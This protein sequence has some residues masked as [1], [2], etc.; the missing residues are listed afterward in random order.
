MDQVSPPADPPGETG[1]TFPDQPHAPASRAPG[2]TVGSVLAWALRQATAPEWSLLRPAEQL[3]AEVHPDDPV[4]RS[5][6]LAGARARL[7]SR[8]GQRPTPVETRALATLAVA[9]NLSSDQPGRARRST[10]HAAGDRAPAAAELAH[11][12]PPG[13]F[14]A[15]R[16]ELLQLA[17]HHHAPPAALQLLLALPAQRVFADLTAALRSAGIPHTEGPR[18]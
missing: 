9:L 14:P 5:A 18:R 8:V 12:L 16:E 1:S 2:R 3:V 15:D 11:Y 13:C 17:V 6:V 7:R 4:L 10:Q